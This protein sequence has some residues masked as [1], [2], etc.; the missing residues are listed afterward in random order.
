MSLKEELNTL[1]EDYKDFGAKGF[2]NIPF[3]SFIKQ[4]PMFYMD[5]VYPFLTTIAGYSRKE[6]NDVKF[7]S[8]YWPTGDIITLEDWD[9]LFK[10]AERLTEGKKIPR[11]VGTIEG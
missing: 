8:K 10:C 1:L 9:Y 5:V 7:T 2:Y 4:F 3:T 6:L 11:Y